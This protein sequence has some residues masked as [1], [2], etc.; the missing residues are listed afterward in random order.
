M[1]DTKFKTTIKCSGCVDKVT[2][3]LNEAVGAG[4]WEVD[5]NSPMKVLTIHSEVDQSKVTKAMEKAG[6]RAEELK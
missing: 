5:L 3:F 6:Y 1:K 2:P 4:N